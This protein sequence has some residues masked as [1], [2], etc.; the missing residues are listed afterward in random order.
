M[1][2]EQQAG[3]NSVSVPQEKLKKVLG[4]QGE[5]LAPLTNLAQCRFQAKKNRKKSPS[6]SDRAAGMP[7]PSDNGC[8]GQLISDPKDR[9]PG[10][11]I[12]EIQ[13]EIKKI[14]GNFSQNKGKRS[15]SAN[16]EARN[17]S[18]GVGAQKNSRG[19]GITSKITDM[20]PPSGNGRFPNTHK[21][22]LDDSEM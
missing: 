21:H 19:I 22:Y 13:E 1:S 15:H 2:P 18:D 14:E 11:Q 20:E 9:I 7:S 6:P 3:I 12:R 16:P 5:D 10:D 8:V 4:N 17:S